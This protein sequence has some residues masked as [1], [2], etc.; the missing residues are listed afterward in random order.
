MIKSFKNSKSAKAASGEK[1]NSFPGLDLGALQKRL[2]SLDAV[3]SLDEIPPLRSIHLHSLQGGRAGQW[4]MNVN[5][6]WRVV[7]EWTDGN[8]DN[9]EVI[10]Y[11]KG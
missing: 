9:V 11:H 10:D 5:G 2:A 8:A 3:K 7:F 4:A 1:V 6:P